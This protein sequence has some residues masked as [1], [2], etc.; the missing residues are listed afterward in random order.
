M[1]WPLLADKMHSD[2]RKLVPDRVATTAQ[3]LLHSG[4]FDGAARWSS[5]P[6]CKEVEA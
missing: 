5:R 2:A 4:G 6:T 3:G 1:V